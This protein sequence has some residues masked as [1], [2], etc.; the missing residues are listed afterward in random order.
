M[1]SLNTIQIDVNTRPQLSGFSG[2]N[3]TITSYKS[4]AKVVGSRQKLASLL[5]PYPL[6]TFATTMLSVKLA[7]YLGITNDSCLT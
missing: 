3:L 6:V 7:K 4:F 1:Y 2:N 5:Y